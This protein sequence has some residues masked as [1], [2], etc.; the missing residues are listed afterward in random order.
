M[1]TNAF[2]FF[3]AALS[4]HYFL[5]IIN[6]ASLFLK[7]FLV[8]T[9]LLKNTSPLKINRTAFYLLIVLVG[10]MTEDAA[11]ISNLLRQVLDIPTSTSVYI[12]MKF[13]ERLSWAFYIIEFQALALFIESLTT[14]TYNLNIRQ[15]I[16]ICLSSSFAT[17]FIASSIWD[18][19]SITPASIRFHMEAFSAVYTI[20][21]LMGISLVFTVKKIRA[22]QS[23]RILKKQLK[24]IIQFLIIPRIISDLIQYFPFHFFPGY[25][26]NTYA[27]VGVSTIILTIALFYCAR[28]VIGLRFLN[29]KSHVQAPKRFNF[30]DGFKEV[31]E[32]LSK[33]TSIQELGHITQTLFKEAFN[34]PSGR[35]ALYIRST[36][37]ATEATTRAEFSKVELITEAFLTN[38]QG[39]IKDFIS[40]HKILIH[41][42][43]DFSNFYESQESGNAV[44][45]FL[46]NI[47]ADIFLPVFKNN[48][49]IAYVVVERFA[50][51]NEFYSDIERDEMLVFASY[52]GNIINLLQNRTFESLIAQEKEIKE[53][54]YKKHQEINQY[55]ES[56]RSFLKNSKHKEIGVIFYKQRHFIFANQIAKE[57]IKVNVHTHI[58]H[59]ITKAL[60]QVAQRVEEYKAPYSLLVKDDENN[61]LML[62]GVP[63]LEQNNVIITVCYP[64][65]VDIISEHINNLKDP[66]KWDYLLYLETTKPGQLI[67][68]L[69]PGS[70]E[71]LLNFKISLLQ[72]ALS[73]KALLLEMAPED[74]IPTVEILHH[75]SMRETL[76]LLTIA[77]PSKNMDI[78]RKLFGV[79]PIFSVETEGKP[80][81]EKLDGSGT[82]FI[83]N[84]EFLDLETQDY[85]AEYIKY[86]FYRVFK[87][88]KRVSSNV[89]I[90]VST[91]QNLHTMVQ[92]GTF[93]SALFA[94]LKR[95]SLS[96]PSLLTLSKDELATLAL[97]YSEQAIKTSDFK[98]LLEL[99]PKD[100]NK[101][102]VARPTSLQEFKSRVQQ[103]LIGKSK[104]TTIDQDIQ[105]DPAYDISDPDL[106]HASR[107]G[108]HALRDPQT[109]ALLWKKFKNQ[110]KIAAFLGVNRSSVNRRCKD[111]KLE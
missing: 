68:Q 91:N 49:I 57:L 60:K 103:L 109:M 99:T 110:N 71:T 84:I 98:N 6:C 88:D 33:V 100:I 13:F 81:L 89:R 76:H 69:I 85:L 26:S 52:L 43:I 23:P 21:I 51:I 111:Y 74:L 15:K 10:A 41:D 9:L 55:K 53:E 58:G 12:F 24:I 72:A 40:E 31:L 47:N 56:I 104:T 102:A 37:P 87:S 44:T 93:S 96:M 67:N 105:F 32:Q 64:D 95:T 66:S 77:S 30:I 14:R 48:N 7:A 94:E 82:L 11:W 2:S 73:K 70:G 28:R 20:C 59:P 22:I 107:L 75:V 79:N 38:E 17:F 46:E 45:R 5:I 4:N 36:A 34:I 16:L 80:L 50:R 29:L 35:I 97:G 19:Y 62:S 54:L 1:I 63:N 18:F 25:T 108:K 3:E 83:Q 78:A 106:I 92:E 42:E 61:K 8:I 39:H 101:L 27:V 65:F 86:G 90:I